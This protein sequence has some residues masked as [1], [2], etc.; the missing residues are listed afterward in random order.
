MDRKVLMWF[1]HVER[2]GDELMIKKLYNSE[3]GGEMGRGKPHFRW[4]D[5][6]KDACKG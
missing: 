4:I 5:G 6:V 1:G 2:I 3:V